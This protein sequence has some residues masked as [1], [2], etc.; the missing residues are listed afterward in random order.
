[1]GDWYDGPFR[2]VPGVEELGRMPHIGQGDILKHKSGA[3]VLRCPACNAMQFARAKVMN[4]DETPTLDQPIQCG[5]GHC[6]KCGVWFTVKNGRAQKAEKPKPKKTE[7]PDKLKKAGVGPPRVGKDP[8][9][10]PRF[11]LRDLH[12]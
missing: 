5:A 10:K 1:M 11:K 3:V 8:P 6:K 12:R 9:V 2:V 4:S 7:L